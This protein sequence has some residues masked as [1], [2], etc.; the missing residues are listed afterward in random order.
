MIQQRFGHH[1]KRKK[2]A[3]RARR[4]LKTFAGRQVRDLERNLSRI[5]LFVYDPRLE[6]YKSVIN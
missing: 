3:E 6:R 4:K 5:T 2:E 1:P